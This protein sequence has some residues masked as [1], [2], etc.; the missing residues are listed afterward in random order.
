MHKILP[1]KNRLRKN[2]AEELIDSNIDVLRDFR[3]KIFKLL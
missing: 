2:V 3:I 1:V